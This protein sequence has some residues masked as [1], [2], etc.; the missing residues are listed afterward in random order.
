VKEN[1][2]LN[3]DSNLEKIN[4]VDQTKKRREDIE[5]CNKEEEKQK[6]SPVIGI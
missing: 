3:Q 1:T 5:L 2:T 4:Y 6:I